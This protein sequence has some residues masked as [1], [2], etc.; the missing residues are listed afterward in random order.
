MS[1]SFLLKVDNTL[2]GGGGKGGPDLRLKGGG[3]EDGIAMIF[4]RNHKSNGGGGM[5][6][7]MVLGNHGPLG[8][9]PPYLHH[10]PE[11][12]LIWSKLNCV[13]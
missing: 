2:G 10:C 7:P 3:A 11:L 8:P 5:W 4:V 9:P 13:Y 1:D 6:G 12:H